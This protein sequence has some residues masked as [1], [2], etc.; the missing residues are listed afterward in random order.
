MK[1]FFG[2]DTSHTQLLYRVDLVLS[3]FSIAR[4]RIGYRISAVK[5]WSLSSDIARKGLIHF[6]VVTSM[7]PIE[8]QN[9][10]L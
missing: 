5:E 10:H 8:L 9:D 4:G 3:A 1:I 6:V 7:N 2:Q